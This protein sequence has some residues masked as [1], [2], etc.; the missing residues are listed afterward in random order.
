MRRTLF[1]LAALLVGV[2]GVTLAGEKSFLRG[3]SEGVY[4][5]LLSCAFFFLSPVDAFDSETMD[6]QRRKKKPKKNKTKQTAPDLSEY[7]AA[8]PSPSSSKQEQYSRP[9]ALQ[10]AFA[11]AGVGPGF[12]PGDGG[13]VGGFDP[14]SFVFGPD[15]RFPFAVPPSATVEPLGEAGAPSPALQQPASAYAAA[16]AAANAP[17]PAPLAEEAAASPAPAS[18]AA[19]PAPSPPVLVQPLRRRLMAE[20]KEEEKE[21]ESESAE[22]EQKEKAAAKKKGGA[23]A[24]APAPSRTPLAERR[25]R[26]SL[27]VHETETEAD[28]QKEAEMMAMMK[29]MHPTAFG[30][31]AER[32]HAGRRSLAQFSGFPFQGG[33]FDFVFGPGSN[34]FTPVERATGG[35]FRGPVTGA[36]ATPVSPIQA[37]APSPPAAPAKPA[38]ASPAPSPAAAAAK[39][40]PASPAPS[41]AAKPKPAALAPSPA[42]AFPVIPVG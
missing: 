1:A 28:E 32:H 34:V 17:S 7:A 12:G 22:E 5:F 20:E 19:A 31:L 26:R 38:A 33:P 13:G 42:A 11:G 18:A 8:S 3:G 4:V 10:Q 36:G 14:F 29:K 24:A 39:P 25:G 16:A 30:A 40:K 35:A 21:E 27:L 41:S 15:A 37:P 9:R 6:T 23:A 2:A